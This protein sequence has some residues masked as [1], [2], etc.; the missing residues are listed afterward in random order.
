MKN[1]LFAGILF[2]I[3]GV[4]IAFGPR[5][6][7]PVCGVRA[8]VSTETD[9]KDP[10]DEECLQTASPTEH[11]AAAKDHPSSPAKVMK[12][13][14]T[15]RAELGVGLLI[16]ILGALLLVF[17][18]KQLRGWLSLLITLSGILALL[19]PTALIGVCGGAHMICRTLALPALSVISSI[20]IIASL[21]N[22]SYLFKSAKGGNIPHETGTPLS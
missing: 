1:R 20:V 7:F 11:P 13:H 2:I 21:I 8:N 6:I 14:R 17:A 15:A 16:S 19:I 3:L 12:C 4:L 22:A 18:S 10:T 5:T 9:C